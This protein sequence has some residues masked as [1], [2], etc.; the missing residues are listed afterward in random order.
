MMVPSPDAASPP[1]TVFIISPANLG[2]D[3]ARLLFRDGATSELARRVRSPGGAPLSDVFSFISSL[4]FRGK[5]TY[6]RAFGR[7]PPGVDGTLVITPGDGLVPAHEPL[8]LERMSAW[9]AVEIDDRND[10]FTAPLV[11]AVEALER[12]HG[13]T[14]RFVLLGSVATNKYVRPLAR[15][16][17][18]HLLFPSEFVG[19][20]DMSRGGLLMRAVRAG[21]ELQYAPVEGAVRHGRRPPRL[22]ARRSGP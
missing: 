8:T 9:A 22:D 20:G 7:S 12:A 1:H 11:S 13:A 3:R 17:G 6:A 2:G 16:F 19:R 10:A 18:D 21:A 14:T 5:I 15:V 4:Y